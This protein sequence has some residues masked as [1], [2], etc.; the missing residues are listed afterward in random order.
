MH[1]F[2]T[3]LSTTFLLCPLRSSAP[4]RIIG[5]EVEVET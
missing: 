1:Q 5:T 3:S 4:L 2:G